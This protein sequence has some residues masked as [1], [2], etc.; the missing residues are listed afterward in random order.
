MTFSIYSLLLFGDLCQ[1]DDDDDDKDTWK[2][3]VEIECKDVTALRDYWNKNLTDP[4]EIYKARIKIDYSLKYSIAQMA[5]VLLVVLTCAFFIR[6]LV[7]CLSLKK[8][9]F[10][11]LDSYRHLVIDFLLILCLLKGYPVA[12]LKLQRWQYHVATFTSFFL[13]FQ[14]MIV[15][16]KY[17]GYGKYVHMFK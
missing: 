17:P 15:A 6:E 8:K 16:G 3:N 7:E 11:K 14:M 1:P 4:R 10:T 9:F 2:W 12:K 5:W 13:W